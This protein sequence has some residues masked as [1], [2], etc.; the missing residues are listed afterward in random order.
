MEIGI[1]YLVNII[2]MVRNVEW[3]IELVYFSFGE[4]Y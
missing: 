2:Y 3:G 4:S 1:L